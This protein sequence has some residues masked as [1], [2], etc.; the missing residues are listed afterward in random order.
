M[1]T[2]ITII[3]FTQYSHDTIGYDAEWYAEV[4]NWLDLSLGLLGLLS[5][6]LMSWMI[7]TRY[8]SYHDMHALAERTLSKICQSIRFPDSKNGIIEHLN[9]Q[10]AVYLA[11]SYTTEIPSKILRAFRDLEHIMCSK[12]YT[13]KAI[14]YERFYYALWK[15]FTKGQYLWPCKI[16][17]VNISKL[18][19]LIGLEFTKYSKGMEDVEAA[20]VQN[21]LIMRRMSSSSPDARSS[22]TRGRSTTNC[23]RSFNNSDGERSTLLHVSSRS[24]GSSTAAEV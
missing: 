15:S 8:Q 14:Q 22:T 19:K 17:S 21:N 5:T 16:P 18:E 12:P 7:N 13:F 23:D 3:A 24:A 6:I 11:V 20:K 9:T 4:K 1:T 10:K 2:F